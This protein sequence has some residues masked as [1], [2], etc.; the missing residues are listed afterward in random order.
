MGGEPLARNELSSAGNA[1][2]VS[3]SKSGKQVQVRLCRPVR[4]WR[5]VPFWKEPDD[6]L[7]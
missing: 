3:A 5:C 6:S 1:S 4:L 2:P 7:W